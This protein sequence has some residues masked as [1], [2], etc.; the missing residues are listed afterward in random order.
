MPTRHAKAV[1]QVSATA[2]EHVKVAPV[3]IAPKA[4][5]PAKQ[6]HS[7]YACRSRPRPATPARRR[8][9]GSPAQRRQHPSQ[10][11]QVHVRATRTWRPSPS[12]ISISPACGR[13]GT[14]SGPGRGSAGEHNA[15]ACR[16]RASARAEDRRVRRTRTPSR[17]CRRQVN[18]RL[19]HTPWHATAD[20]RARLLRRGDDAQLVC[21]PTAAGAPR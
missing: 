2:S 12:S 6:G 17:T 19:S 1:H 4:A 7:A 20:P 21:V 13:R 14:G 11:G 16:R 9:P 3:R 8:G 18:T 15:P 5:A 10:R